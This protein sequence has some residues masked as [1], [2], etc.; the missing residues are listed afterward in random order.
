MMATEQ[1]GLYIWMLRDHRGLS[2]EQ[3]AEATGVRYGTIERLEK[4]DPMVA[5]STVAR[6]IAHVGASPWYYCLL[7]TDPS[8]S[9]DEIFHRMSVVDGIAAFIRALAQHDALP[10]DVLSD[11]MG[12]SADR[13]LDESHS[14]FQTLP[15]LALIQGLIALNVPISDLE[16]IMH[17]PSNH[18][19]LGQ[20]IGME[21]AALLAQRQ[22]EHPLSRS[23][24]SSFPLLD[25]ALR[26]LTFLHH[27]QELMSS[28]LRYELLRAIADIEQFRTQISV[29]TRSN[30]EP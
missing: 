17:A 14:T 10:I 22:I 12:V 5:V 7:A 9:L 27:N 11:L 15:D 26:R 3:V 29:L 8:L 6:V 18:R 23:A 16:P 20:Q 13:L 24:H 21:R 19:E 28:I 25:T 30:P 4:G 1:S 2:R